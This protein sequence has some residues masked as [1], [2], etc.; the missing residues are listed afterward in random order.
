MPFSRITSV[1][2][3]K[4]YR[5]TMNL[6]MRSQR[7]LMRTKGVNGYLCV[8]P[9]TA[10]FEYEGMRFIYHFAEYGVAGNIDAAGSAEPATRAKL[11]QLLAP[12]MTFYDVGAHEGLFTLDV[13]KS[14]PS[15]TVHSFEPLPEVLFQ[16]LQLNRIE[17]VTVHAVAVG[18]TSGEISITANLRSSNHISKDGARKV[19]VITLDSLVSERGVKPPDVMKMDVEGYELHALWGSEK[20]LREHQPL[21]ITEINHCIMRYHPSMKPFLE[22]MGKLGY[23]LHTLAD[24]HLSAVASSPALEQLDNLPASDEFNYWWVPERFASKIS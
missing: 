22:Y 11:R 5:L 24:G 3:D 23:Q 7:A 1:V 4:S 8:G 13:G 19:P 21:V 18:N 12:D 10:F 16:N 14:F 17:H 20:L 15:I 2:A 9:D 6:I